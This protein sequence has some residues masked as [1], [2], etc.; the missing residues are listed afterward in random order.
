MYTPNR[1]LKERR[2]GEGGGGGGGQKII[3]VSGK[4]YE[5]AT[6]IHVEI[7][8][9]CIH[10]SSQLIIKSRRGGGI[11]AP[12]PPTPTGSDPT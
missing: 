10:I 7:C 5:L 11:Q 9:M 12:E 2:E 3:W 8:H 1:V 4:L 6:K